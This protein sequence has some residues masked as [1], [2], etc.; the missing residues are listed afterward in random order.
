MSDDPKPKL[1]SAKVEQVKKFV[2]LAASPN[3]AEAKNAAYKACQLIRALGLD[4]VDP[5]AINQV[6]VELADAQ[7]QV[8]QLSAGAAP[9]L[10]SLTLDS[11]TDVIHRMNAPPPHV[12][13]PSSGRWRRPVLDP[14]DSTDY[15]DILRNLRGIPLK[16]DP[17]PM[18]APVDITTDYDRQAC[19]YCKRSIRRGEK[20][21][22]MKGQ[23]I[24]CPLPADCYKNWSTGKQPAPFAGDIADL[25]K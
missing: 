4:I 13:A 3:L 11:L 2:N 6:F 7:K 23:G 20:A 19:L 18:T 24:W 14:V 25:F 9:N 22:W 15:D 5:E 10:G 16:P 1:D 21:R 12:S 8:K 17:S